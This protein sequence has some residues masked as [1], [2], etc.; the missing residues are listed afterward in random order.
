[1]FIRSDYSGYNDRGEQIS[2]GLF[3]ILMTKKEDMALGHGSMRA[4]VRHTKLRQFGHF[5]MGRAR[6]GNERVTLSGSYGSDGLPM[7]VSDEVWNMGIPVPD[8]LYDAWN[9]GGGWNSSGAEGP[10]LRRWALENLS[11]LRPKGAKL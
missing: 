10:D 11:A 3:L 4:I 7:S 2:G 5:M 1:M 9:N 8:D 6:I